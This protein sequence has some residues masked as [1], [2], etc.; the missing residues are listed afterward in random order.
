MPTGA[1]GAAPQT[2]TWTFPI[3][4]HRVTVD[5]A[6]AGALQ[7]AV[8]ASPEPQQGL[9]LGHRRPGHTQIEAVH[10]IPV[11]DAEVVAAAIGKA[12]LAAVGYY[13]IREGCAFILEA[14]EMALAKSAFPEAGSVVL[15]I[16]RRA[17]GPAEGTFCFWR[18]EAFVSNLPHPFPIDPEILAR[19]PQ[20]AEPVEE[21]RKPRLRFLRRHAGPLGVLAAS[22]T[23]LIML[24]L[25]WLRTEPPPER[26]T[27]APP[28]P[29]I[30]TEAPTVPVSARTAGDVEIAWDRQGLGTATAG[31]LKI[32]DGG[33][34][35]HIPL[36]LAQLRYGSIV[37]SPG[38]GPVTADLKVLQ[39][40]GQMLDIAVSAA[41]ARPAQTPVTVTPPRAAPPV[42]ERE[43]GPAPAPP[44]PVVAMDRRAPAKRFDPVVSR[45]P[46]LSSAPVLPDAPQVHPG[47]PSAPVLNAVASGPPPAPVM[48]VSTPTRIRLGPPVERVAPSLEHTVGKGSGRL[49]WTGTLLRRGVVEFE[50]RSVSVGSLNGALPGVPVHVT[51]SPAE[52]GSDGLVVYT[53]DPR[54][55]N[56]VEAP[57]AANGWNRIT[58]IWDPERVRQI[59]V[60]EAPNPSNRF[61]HL[62]LRSDA[63]RCSMLVIDWTAR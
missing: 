30:S 10:P 34:R 50:G 60:L 42:R 8:S 5:L 54:L 49:I 63:R 40:D 16:E 38:T 14:P 13:R 29:V 4:P 27:T 37:Y 52:F 9:L 11:L 26:V 51:V 19:E 25:I 3:C 23:A 21:V 32:E 6:V 20:P 48:A 45:R 47:L 43:K 31:L 44:P 36:D 55:H 12:S 53:T 46:V 15:L 56:H 35:H 41:P 57:S 22:V 17:S 7:K 2:Y 24:P 59:A 62:A 58:Y 18:G 61:S 33:V 28:P 39:L 1:V